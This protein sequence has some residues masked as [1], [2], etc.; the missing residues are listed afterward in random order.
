VQ[1]RGAACMTENHVQ[2]MMG[3]RDTISSLAGGGYHTSDDL[4]RLH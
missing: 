3:W 1:G 4:R 2:G